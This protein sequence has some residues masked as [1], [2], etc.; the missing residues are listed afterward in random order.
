MTDIDLPF[1]HVDNSTEVADD[2]GVYAEA[3]LRDGV[4]L[5]YNDQD[6]HYHCF[7]SDKPPEFVVKVLLADAITK[8][9]DFQK[10]EKLL[11]D[12]ADYTWDYVE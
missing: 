11:K 9:I 8:E 3:E 6:H 5:W 1:G 2:E 4:H 12:H 10:A 7:W